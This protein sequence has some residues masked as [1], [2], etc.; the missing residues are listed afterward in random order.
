MAHKVILPP[1]KNYIPQFLKQRDINSYI[2][3]LT[4]CAMKPRR[5]EEKHTPICIL[6]HCWSIIFIPLK[7]SSDYIQGS[8]LWSFNWRRMMH[9][10]MHLV[11]YS[12]SYQLLLQSAKNLHVFAIA[13]ANQPAVPAVLLFNVKGLSK[14]SLYQTPPTPLFSPPSTPLEYTRGLARGSHLDLHLIHLDS[15]VS[16]TWTLTCSHLDLL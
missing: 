11:S 13:I 10:T 6:S 7:Y 9:A 12:M 15:L 14:Y 1:K 3:L 5:S 4:C 8:S 2:F 16:H